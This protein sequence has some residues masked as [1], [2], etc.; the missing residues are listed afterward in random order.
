M[1][2]RDDPVHTPVHSTGSAAQTRPFRAPPGLRDRCSSGSR[3][4][5]YGH[6][7]GAYVPPKAPG[8]RWTA[9]TEPRRGRGATSAYGVPVQPA[10]KAEP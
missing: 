6:S 5:R 1:A 8:S 7:C 3:F 4:E 10:G 9:I 2:A